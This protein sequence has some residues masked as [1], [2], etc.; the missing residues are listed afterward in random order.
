MR[1]PVGWLVGYPFEI[2]NKRLNNNSVFLSFSFL[3]CIWNES[4]RFAV[5]S[6][7]RLFDRLYTQR[8]FALFLRFLRWHFIQHDTRRPHCLY[9]LFILLCSQLF[10]VCI[11]L[12]LS[13]SVCTTHT[14]MR[15][16]SLPLSM[17][18]SIVLLLFWIGDS[19]AYVDVNL[20]RFVVGSSFFWWWCNLADFVVRCL[21]TNCEY[22]AST[23]FSIVCWCCFCCCCCSFVVFSATHTLPS[24]ASVNWMHLRLYVICSCYIHYRTFTIRWCR[25]K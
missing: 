21:N 13:L 25:Y 1:L 10:S 5:V 18:M 2:G 24:V 20:I 12:L 23:A 4:V 8:Q 9:L 17:C 7:A 16:L 6:M 3:L 19:N 15:A 11:N 22:R 14:H